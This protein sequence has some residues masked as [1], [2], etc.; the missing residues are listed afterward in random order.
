MWLLGLAGVGLS[1]LMMMQDLM[2]A[3]REGY[4]Y[5]WSESLLF[6]A[7]GV[8]I[9]PVFFIFRS[10]L[11]KEANG[12]LSITVTSLLAMLTHMVLYALLVW[13]VSALFLD[14]QYDFLRNLFYTISNDLVKYLLL[15]GGLVMYLQPFRKQRPP[16][17][18][19]AITSGKSTTLLDL[20]DIL[21]IDTA[22]PYIAVHTPDRKHLLTQSLN[23][24][25]EKLDHR[26]VR[27]HR[28]TIVNIGAVKKWTS[29]GN[30]DYDLLLA[31]DK[32]LRLS[33]RYA[34]DFWKAMAPGTPLS[35]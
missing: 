35:Q 25:M 12:L 28:S 16:V 22:D 30:G 2:G 10:R 24:V 4:T 33:R 14:H 1:L 15:Y 11:R 26:F 21:F 19:L 6:S 3:R 5:Y 9:V 32:E 23:A 31:D 27:I 7:Y 34:S 13:L 29:R 20:S 8:L 18:S 17:A